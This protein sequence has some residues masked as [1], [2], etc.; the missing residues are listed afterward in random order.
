MAR[1]RSNPGIAAALVLSESA[2]EKHVS[3]IFAKLGLSPEQARH[4]GPDIPARFPRSPASK[5]EIRT[6][7]N[8]T[9]PRT[10]LNGAFGTLP[11]Y[12]RRK[13]THRQSRASAR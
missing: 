5:G 11:H 7:R 2:V 6:L 9:I 4:G 10:V 8:L 13:D 12:R 3:S 1:G